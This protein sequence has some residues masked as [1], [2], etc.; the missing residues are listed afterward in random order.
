VVGSAFF[1]GLSMIIASIVRTRE[2]MMGIGQ[3]ATM[4]LFFASS[5]L[6]PVKAMPAWLQ[7]FAR[8][9][10]MSFLVDGLRGLLLD[11]AYAGFA[12]DGGAL[13]LMGLAALAI[14][15]WRYPKLLL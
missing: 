9:N 7:A 10:P 11:P 8:V 5:A 4:P 3:L 6:Y 1:T 12:L 15:T 14:A 2:R 13:L